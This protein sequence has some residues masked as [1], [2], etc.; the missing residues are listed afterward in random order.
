MKRPPAQARCVC[1]AHA[2]VRPSRPWR[3]ASA[4]QPCA[5]LV[6][7]VCGPTRPRPPPPPPALATR[8]SRASWTCRPAATPFHA[9]P[10]SGARTQGRMGCTY[11]SSGPAVPG[12]RRMRDGRVGRPA[13]A[14]RPMCE[15]AC[16]R[17]QLFPPLISDPLAAPASSQPASN[18]PASNQPASHHP[19]TPQ[20]PQQAAE[21]AVGVDCRALGAR[22]RA[23]PAALHQCGHHH[24]RHGR[25]DDHLCQHG[26]S[27]WRSWGGWAALCVCRL[28]LCSGRLPPL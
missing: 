3:I 13:F 24:P 15:T 4:R 11:T 26:G 7:D 28:Q 6:L 21:P 17:P 27:G 16:H 2:Y 5:C 18:Q 8:T 20:D 9:R 23:G 25:P 19:S 12:G 10:S 22:H 1:I 14:K